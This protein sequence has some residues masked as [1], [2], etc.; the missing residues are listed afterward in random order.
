MLGTPRQRALR[1]LH[2][3]RPDID[4]CMMIEGYCNSRSCVTEDY[5]D[6][7]L[8][9]ASNLR[10]NPVITFEVCV[11][12]DA[13]LLENTELG[14]MQKDS[15]LRIQ[16]FQDNLEAKFKSFSE[17][18]YKVIVRCKRCGSDDVRWE[19]KQTRSADEGATVFCTCNSCKNRWTT[20]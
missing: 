19:E 9:C 8:R 2:K 10:A 17:G 3:S 6:D 11:A 16:H 1:L 15:Q 4:V 13:F 12:T 18:T 5:Y 7:I 20:R 14:Q